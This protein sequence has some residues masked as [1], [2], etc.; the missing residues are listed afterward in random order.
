MIPSLAQ[1]AYAV[2]SALFIFSLYWMNNPQTA[3]KSVRA[4]VIAMALA[5]AATWIQPGIVHHLWI[6]LAILA[7]VAVGGPACSQ[8]GFAP[9][10]TVIGADVT[11]GLVTTG[12][13]TT[14]GTVDCDTVAGAD[15]TGDAVVGG[16][17]TGEAEVD[18]DATVAVG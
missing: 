11:G 4:G 15:V 3:R 2:A 18:V 9:A 10:G 13:S 17:V 1:L 7:G 6:I 5:M 12:P 16:A 14:A 8:G